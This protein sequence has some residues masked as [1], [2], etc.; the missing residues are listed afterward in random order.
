MFA[1]PDLY[2]PGAFAED[3]PSP[4][5]RSTLAWG[6]GERLLASLIGFLRI[7]GLLVRRRQPDGKAIIP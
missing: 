1:I 6:D 5:A 7:R 4:Y 2:P 3:S